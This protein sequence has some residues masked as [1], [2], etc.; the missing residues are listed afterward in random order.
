MHPLVSIIIPTFNSDAFLNNTLSSV[1][2]QS[3]SSWECLII[4]DGSTDNTAKIISEYV[5]SDERFAF[6]QRPADRLKG[7]NACRNIGLEH[8]NGEYLMFLDA[9]D[10]LTKTCLEGRLSIFDSTPNVDIVVADTAPLVDGEFKNKSINKDPDEASSE[11]YLKMFLGYTIP[12]TIMSGLWKTEW[13]KTKRF[14]ESLNRFQ[15]ID[16][17]ISCLKDPLSI[18]RFNR[19]DNY[20]RLESDK[21]KNKAHV[22][23]VLTN[24]KLF[25][26]KQMNFVQQDQS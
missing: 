22:R 7:A 11:N 23:S 14:D 17:H 24:F 20:Y 18:K 3:H 1:V 25:Y 21:L 26:D 12:W 8:C 19:I 10:V 13:L 9:D 5:N 2:D 16:F 4:D 15:D 6:H